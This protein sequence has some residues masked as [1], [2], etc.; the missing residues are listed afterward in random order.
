[1]AILATRNEY[2]YHLHRPEETGLY[3]IIQNHWREF[4]YY[5]E[6]PERGKYLPSFVKKEV[7][8]YLKCGLPQFGFVRIYCHSCGHNSLVPFSCKRRGFCPSCAGRRMTDTSTFFINHIMPI[9]PVRQWVLSL[10]YDVRF[11]IA[12]KPKLTSLVL[13]IFI[14][15]INR[16][17][18]KKAKQLKNISATIPGSVTFIQRFGSSLNLNVHFHSLFIDGVYNSETLEFIKLPAP[19]DK[20]LAKIII[21]IDRRVTKL[22]KNHLSSQMEFPEESMGKITWASI[23]YKRFLDYQS[24]EKLKMFGKIKLLEPLIKDKKRVGVRVD[25]FSLHAGVAVSANQ[26][27]KLERIIRYTARGPISNARIFQ[28]SNGS[29]LYQL[30][31]MWDDGTTHVSFSP[32]DFIARIVALI[33]PPRA[34]LVRFHGVLAPN[35]KHRV[36]IVPRLAPKK[37]KS[38]PIDEVQK[39]S[40]M[41]WA[42]MLRKVFKIDVMECPKCGGRLEQIA[43]INDYKVARKI[44]EAMGR[45]SLPPEI[46]IFRSRGPPEIKSIQPVPENAQMVDTL[47]QDW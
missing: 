8:E 41:K 17:L 46:K 40:R 39:E 36:K 42:D 1:M 4:L 22:I 11:A 26:R 20:E 31:K 21:T 12:H 5:A 15:T 28:N 34:H 25:G 19:T 9:A 38:E 33:P 3:K 23:T 13:S 2:S 32:L 14:Q 6:D 18:R 16:H 43:T 47:P 30:K 10:P 45:D 35:Y 27:T 7:S 44:L 29:V 24:G 37:G